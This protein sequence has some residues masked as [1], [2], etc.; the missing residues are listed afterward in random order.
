MRLVA[1]LVGLLAAILGDGDLCVGPEHHECAA[2]SPT[3]PARRCRES[4]SNSE[5]EDFALRVAQTDASGYYAFESAA[6]GSVQ[7]FFLASRVSSIAYANALERPL[8]RL[9]SE[10]GWGLAAC[11]RRPLRWSAPD[12]SWV[13]SNCS[14]V[15][16]HG[17]GPTTSRRST[18]CCATARA[19]A[20]TAS[21]SP[22]WGI[23]ARGTAT[24]Q[25]PARA[26][27]NGV[28]G[29]FGD[30]DATDGGQSSRY[31][32][33]VEWQRTRGAAATKITAYGLVYDLDLFSNFTYFLD[34]P[35]NGDQFQ[36]A[37]QAVR[38][39]RE[40]QPPAHGDVGWPA[41]AEQRRRAVAARRDRP[42]RALSVRPADNASRPSDR[43][44]SR[45]RAWGAFAQNETEWTPWLRTWRGGARRRLPV[46][47]P[48]Q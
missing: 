29:R 14:T 24:D 13:R 15:T 9:G 23:A 11:W 21:R 22:R 39:R 34:D 25:I 17:I 35:V 2:R 28:I 46:W 45:R 47:R 3:R 26:V 40:G 19:M 37:E 16:G 31:S 10:E 7:V 44:R 32:A 20:S 1:G 8:L 5:A 41:R 12:G 48:G 30:V 18:A 4:S 27:A 43:M 36:Q 38:E 42:C 33:S 6:R